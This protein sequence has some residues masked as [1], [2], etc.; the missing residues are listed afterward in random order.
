MASIGYLGASDDPAIRIRKFFDEIGLLRSVR[1]LRLLRPMRSNRLQGFK[2]CEITTE[3]S[4]SSR[5]LN[6][7]LF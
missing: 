7:A 5:F 4:E 1:P 2:A 3:D 6:S